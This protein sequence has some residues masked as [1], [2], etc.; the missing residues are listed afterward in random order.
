M[1]IYLP[2]MYLVKKKKNQHFPKYVNG[3]YCNWTCE[4]FCLLW[5]VMCTWIRYQKTIM[6]FQARKDLDIQSKKKKSVLFLNQFPTHLK[7]EQN[8]QCLG[9][10]VF[11]MKVL[12]WE[13]LRGR[14]AFTWPVL[15]I[16]HRHK[17]YLNMPKEAK[18]S[19]RVE[20]TITAR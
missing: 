15:L 3:C 12:P 2:I 10:Q 4:L 8:G 19:W 1:N 5:V 20:P 17:Y 13:L 9:S 18:Y 11:Y 6:E 16:E 14:D 7:Q